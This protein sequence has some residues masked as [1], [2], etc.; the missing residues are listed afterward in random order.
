[1]PY[2]SYESNLNHESNLSK[3]IDMWRKRFL[4]NFPI[5]ENSFKERYIYEVF[6]NLPS[7]H[8]LSKDPELWIKEIKHDY[9][10]DT[11]K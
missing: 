11:N 2:N 4:N 6:K 3:E 8:M 9:D 1:M 10:M 5:E 7:S